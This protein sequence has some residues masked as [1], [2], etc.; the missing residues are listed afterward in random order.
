MRPVLL[1]LISL[2]APAALAQGTATPAA[3]ASAEPAA[4]PAAFGAAGSNA[5]AVNVY[6]PAP[7]APA[8]V[9]ASLPPLPPP[10]LAEGELPVFGQSLFQGRFA[11]ESFRGFNPD[12]LISVGDTI[13]VRLWGVVES[14]MVLTVDAQGNIFV[15]RVGPIA[16][17]NVRNGSLNEVVRARL[18]SIYR[19]D[20][21]VYATLAAAVPVKLF[22][23]GAVRAPGL[24]PGF[25]ADSLLTF[26][27]RAGGVEPLSGSYLDVRLLRGGQTVQTVSLYDFLTRG[28]LPLLQLRDG[29]T[30]FVGPQGPTVSVIGLVATPA[31]YEFRGDTP[32]REVLR[33]AGVSGRATH[34]RISRN[35]G[36]RR[37]VAYVRLEDG[38]LDQPLRA[39]DEIEVT[40]ERLLG[41]ISVAVEGEHQG[42]AQLVLPYAATL[43]DALT[44]M[45]YSPQSRPGSL[46]LFRRSV[47]ERQKQVLDEMLRKLEQSVLA[48]R[49]STVEE[50]QLRTQEAELILQ[51]VERARNIR[52]R[53]QVILAEDLD[54]ATIA[55]EDGDVLKVPRGTQVV[56]VHG[57]VYY[58][59]AFLWQPG[60]DVVDYIKQAGG[61][62]QKSA[63]DR[64]LLIRQSGQ[65]ESDTRSGFLYSTPVRAGDEILVL[66][67]VDGKE[68]Q[69]AKDIIQV[70]YQIAIAAGVVAR[71]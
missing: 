50:V 29:D 51:F 31:Q 57:E 9:P 5:P 25:A 63:D 27:D 23:S 43:Q 46:Q 39:A 69:F 41:Q 11:A 35:T 60:L 47:A 53:G 1:V 62:I 26:L 15:P 54:P 61:V 6:A 71:L 7:P 37:E 2:A 32:I 42:A 68:Y 4:P 30:L 17:A 18:R 56:Q 33:M 52:P 59:N 66:P 19:E 38:F 14:Q 40:A 3:P 28:E 64:V 20:V 65:I 55:L 44:Q 48:A 21:G 34:V 70:I 24:Y 58:P 12:Y 13:D 45:Q 67:A 10:A 16:V 49:S 36:D 22:V 8:P